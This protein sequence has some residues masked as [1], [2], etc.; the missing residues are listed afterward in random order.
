MTHHVARD[1]PIGI[2]TASAHPD[3]MGGN[4][5]NFQR[6]ARAARERG[7]ECVVVSILPDGAVRCHAADGVSAFSPVRLPDVPRV[8]YNRIPTRI[9]ERKA[10]VR[11]RL[12]E[13]ERAGVVI[14]NPGFL[15]KLDIHRCW[16]GQEALRPS[17]LAAEEWR[18][19][20]QLQGFS[21][22]YSRFYAKPVDGKAGVGIMRVERV[23]DSYTVREQKKGCVVQLDRLSWPELEGYARRKNICGRYLLQQEAHTAQYRDRRFDLRLLLHRTAPAS[24]AVT[25][26]GVRLAPPAGITTHVPNG[27]QIVDVRRVLREVF[28]RSADTV[29]MQAQGTAVLAANAI[30][31]G[32][33]TW[34]ELSIDMGLLPSGEPCL[35]EA[36]AKPMKFDES[37]IEREAKRRLTGALLALAEAHG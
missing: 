30:A 12:R 37:P 1:W 3:R 25:G 8:L 36:N 5:A 24:F 18:T 13:W 28:G 2:L 20:D 23:G 7:A 33:G 34:T 17:L 21:A 16:S 27:G 6:I 31:Q 14:T 4:Q 22:R 32:V 11:R 10:H 9:L 29:A 19:A 35:F 15:S 26:M